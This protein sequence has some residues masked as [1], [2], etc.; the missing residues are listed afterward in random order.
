MPPGFV[1]S[2]LAIK[3][4]G[5]RRRATEARRCS[6]CQGEGGYQGPEGGGGGLAAPPNPPNRGTRI[7]KKVP[8]R[9]ESPV[10]EELG[11]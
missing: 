9:L 8:N 5:H 10:A 11:N 6:K 4:V 3:F 1:V 2:Q 7:S